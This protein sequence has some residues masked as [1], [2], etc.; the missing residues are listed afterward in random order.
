MTEPRSGNAAPESQRFP[1]PPFTPP[2]ATPAPWPLNAAPPP[3]SVPEPAAQRSFSDDTFVP[4]PP[5]LPRESVAPEA[6][7]ATEPDDLMPWEAAWATADEI[8]DAEALVAPEWTEPT[9]QVAPESAEPAWLSLEDAE[10]EPVALAELAPMEAEPEADEVPAWLSWMDEGEAAGATESISDEIGLVEVGDLGAPA[11]EPAMEAWVAD[12]EDAAGVLPWAAEAEE[13]SPVAGV[14]FAADAEMEDH[15]VAPAVW[16]EPNVPEAE[17]AE[18]WAEPVE[19][20]A[21][22]D[23]PFA[24]LAERLERLAAELRSESPAALL[25]GAGRDPLEVLILG[26]ALGQMHAARE[27]E[28]G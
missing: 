3:F 20:P 27:G 5:P 12:E 24:A 14:E 13:A 17:S 15:S 19:A 7:A 22:A 25:A 18:F 1:L 10:E 6:A 26:Y 4:E 9:M 2:A 8:A 28:R 23:A 11:A 16:M 21:P